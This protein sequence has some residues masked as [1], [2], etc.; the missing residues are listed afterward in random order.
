[1]LN[2][3]GNQ[4]TGATKRWEYS[5]KWIQASPFIPMYMYLPYGSVQENYDPHISA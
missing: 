1:M 4:I 2:V 3:R 5:S